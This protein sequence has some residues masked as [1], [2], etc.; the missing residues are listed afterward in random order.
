MSNHTKLEFIAL[1]IWGN[2]YL[3]CIF[4]VKIHLDAM[5]LGTTIK[6]ENLISLQDR[7]K[8][9]IFL[10]HHLHEGLKNDYLTVNDHFSLWSNMKKRYDHQKIVI[11]LE[12]RYDWIHL[13]L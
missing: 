10:C 4:D 3:S 5:N 6:E 7:A 8:A 9:L 13:R 2:N 12:A 1:D 11:L